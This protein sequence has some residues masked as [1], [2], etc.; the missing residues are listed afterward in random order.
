MKYKLLVWFSKGRRVLASIPIADLLA[1]SVAV[2][3]I[4]T[5]G[6]SIVG[7]N[8]KPETLPFWEKSKAVAKVFAWI[9]APILVCKTWLEY[10]RRKYDP[11]LMFTLQKDFDALDEERALAAT[12]CI[13]FLSGADKEADETKRWTLVDPREREKVEPVLDF[14]E[15]VGF[16]LKGDQ[17]SDDVV[18]HNS[19]HWIRGWYPKRID[20][21][22]NRRQSR[23]GC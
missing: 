18:H 15:D 6:A 9:L 14:F 23:S 13:A 16:Y 1:F 5:I 7:G 12:V 2:T 22:S 4:L 20:C 21:Y 3:A 11:E 8:V 19:H 17:F 10:N